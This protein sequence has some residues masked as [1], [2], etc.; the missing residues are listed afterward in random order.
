MYITMRDMNRINLSLA[1]IVTPR[2]IRIMCD[3]YNLRTQHQSRQ[4]KEGG[5]H[6]KLIYK[7][8]KRKVNE[9]QSWLPSFHVHLL[10]VYLTA[11]WPCTWKVL[12]PALRLAPFI[13]EFPFA[14][15]NDTSLVESL[16]RVSFNPRIFLIRPI[17]YFTTLMTYELTVTYTII[18]FFDLNLLISTHII[19]I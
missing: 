11:W 6:I 4:R 2:C 19:S 3:R 18:I 15:S 5:R 8:G 9:E 12:Y 14:E 16:S 7:T 13:S 1:I 10:S 17:S